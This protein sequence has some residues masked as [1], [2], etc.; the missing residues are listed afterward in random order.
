[1]PLAVGGGFG[2]VVVLG[3]GWAGAGA[4]L[5]PL[6]DSPTASR[7]YPDAKRWSIAVGPVN[8]PIFWV[9]GQ[10]TIN[11]SGVGALSDD[12]NPDPQYTTY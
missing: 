10:Y 12:L 4:A 5:A 3:D 11:S 9:G 6:G 8:P 1:M 2:F 7:G